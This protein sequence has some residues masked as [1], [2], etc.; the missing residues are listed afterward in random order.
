M[1]KFFALIL[2]AVLTING[3]RAEITTNP[4]AVVDLVNRVC[5]DGAS[6]HFTFVLDTDFHDGTEAFQLASDG[7]GVIITANTLSAMTRGLG[8]YLNHDARVNITWN[9]L[10][11]T[12][13][14]YPAPNDKSVHSTDTKYR[15]YL[16]YCTF[17]YTMAF[18]TWERWQEEI[19]W[20]ALHGV[21]MPLNIVGLDVV[22]KNMLTEM[23]YSDQ[24]ISKFIAGPG[25]QAWWAMINHEGH[26]GPNPDWWYTRSEKLGKQI[27]ERE[28]ALGMEPVIPGYSGQMPSKTNVGLPS[29]GSYTDITL[30][31]PGNWASGKPTPSLLSPKYSKYNEVA[32]LYYKHLHQ[33]MGHSKYYSM[34]LFHESGSPFDGV[35]AIDFYKNVYKQMNTNA[36]AESQ[37]VMQMWQWDSNQATSLDAFEKGRLIVLDLWSEAS[38]RFGS[39]GGNYKGHESV[40]C[41]LHNFGG[42]T[43][44]HGRL[45]KTV[46][47]Y[48]T[49]K[50]QYSGIKGV[51]CTPEG[52][53]TNPILYEAVYEM[54]WANISNVDAWLDEF[55]KCRY[56]NDDQR[57]RHA[58]QLLREGPLGCTTNQQGTSEPLVCARPSYTPTRV[59]SWSTANIYWDPQ[60]VIEAA[61]MYLTMRSSVSGKNFDYDLA[62]CMRQALV[63]QAKPLLDAMNEAK[64]KNDATELVRL[65]TRFLQLIDDLDHLLLTRDDFSLYKWTQG[66]RAI[67]AEVGVTSDEAKNWMELNA[68]MQVTTWLDQAHV[69]GLN[70]YSNRCWSGLLKGFYRERWQRFFAGQDF[71]FNAF[72]RSWVHDN[73]NQ[74]T[75]PETQEQTSII[76]AELFGKYF[77]KITNNQGKTCYFNAALKNTNKD[78]IDDAY[79]GEEYIPEIALPEGVTIISK[80][81]GNDSKSGT[82]TCSLELSDGTSIV[83]SVAVRAKITENRTL[84]VKAGE[85]GTVNVSADDAEV[86]TVEGNKSVTSMH[87]IVA[88][89]TANDNYEFD[90]WIDS[91]GNEFTDNP[92]VYYGAEDETLTAMFVASKWNEVATNNNEFSVMASNKQYIARFMVVE[93]EEDRE[94]FIAES[95][96]KTLYMIVPSVLKLVRGAKQSIKWASADQTNNNDG[97]ECTRFSG[98]LDMNSNGSFAD[99]GELIGSLG[100]LNAKNNAMHNA[101]ITFNVPADAPLGRTRMRLRF[102][103]AWQHTGNAVVAPEATAQRMVYDI[104][105]EIV[106]YPDYIVTV[107]AIVDESLGTLEEIAGGEF[108]NQNPAHVNPGKEVTLRITEKTEGSFT[109]WVD[110]DGNIISTEKSFTFRPKESMVLTATFNTEDPKPHVF[111]GDGA[112]HTLKPSE[113]GWDGDVIDAE[114]KWQLDMELESDGSSFNQWGSSLLATG[115]N[116]FPEKTTTGMGFQFYLQSSTNGGNLLYVNGGDNIFNNVHYNTPIFTISIMYDG[117]GKATVT[118]TPKDGEKV[119]KEFSKTYNSISNFAYAMPVGMN[120]TSIA[121]RDLSVPTAISRHEGSAV[122]KVIYD[123]QGRIVKSIKHKAIYIASGKKIVY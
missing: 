76:A 91:K 52:T 121:I 88:T 106:E 7:N 77:Y 61:D 2:C 25:F 97:M 116:A 11:Q 72:E 63:D 27:L 30:N 111:K 99:S 122:P 19:D 57:L 8:W 59:S 102:D 26:G 16:N 24:Q 31:T 115:T 87:D 65:Q 44:I 36:G 109:G 67:P 93:G 68:R 74:Y 42:R 118:V 22:W 107:Q 69:G 39:Y 33:V 14:S 9:N 12:P 98:Y 17:S 48:Y 20:M 113:I 54:P 101:T 78:F 51:G 34:D 64:T 60:L 28:R 119:Q 96:P 35:A 108:N 70:D 82:T 104:P 90:R 23:G 120:I 114:A 4:N 3:L 10:H 13:L 112:Q 71:G 37:C 49:Y 81:L 38:P 15:Y 50:N 55:V 123:L 105:V 80:K 83:Y 100:S 41:M 84:T 86:V 47:D 117:A 66:A 75:K 110:H 40:Y 29:S 6:S 18:Y 95:D 58:W 53:E 1:K 79:L 45:D 94:F 89:A 56:N 21:N 46:K 92:Y 62:D 32:A 5:G 43:G 73:T 103:G 85:N